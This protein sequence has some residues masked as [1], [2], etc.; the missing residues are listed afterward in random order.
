MWT[1]LARTMGPDE[2]IFWGL[3]LLE[4]LT[5]PM[6]RQWVPGYVVEQYEHANPFYKEVL[7]ELQAG[8]RTNRQLLKRVRR[9]M[10][11]R[12]EL[13]LRRKRAEGQRPRGE[14]E[15]EGRGDDASTEGS[16][17]GAGEDPGENGLQGGLG[18]DGDED[19]NASER[20]KMLR[21][22]RPEDVGEGG[23][24]VA[25]GDSAGWGRRDAEERLSA[26][27]PAAQ[28]PDLHV[29]SGHGEGEGAGSGRG[30][31]F[32]PRGYDW[33]RDACNVSQ[34]EYGRLKALADQWYGKADV[35]D[36]AAPVDQEGVDDWPM[37][38]LAR[39]EPA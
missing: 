32:N 36:G 11:A 28:A 7:M 15:G 35:G 8:A 17:D 21:E 4:M 2:E 24:V 33:C 22:P 34:T 27:G 1:A 25:D 16:S 18:V 13:A 10:M 6:L 20:L 39:Q 26:A 14:G 19:P 9:A 12:Q 23:G 29:G 37:G 38:P 5:D 30:V 31:L 3:K